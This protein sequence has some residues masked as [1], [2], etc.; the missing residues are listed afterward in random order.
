M[1]SKL[2]LLIISIVVLTNVYGSESDTLEDRKSDKYVGKQLYQVYCVQC[3]GIT[4]D[5]YGINVEDMSVLP[6]DHTDTK[7]MITRSD[8]DL[9]KAIKYGGKAV[10]KSV[11]MPAC[12][13]NLNDKQIDA[14][15]VY[16]RDVCCA[17]V[18]EQ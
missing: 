1:I 4:G 16:L 7:E 6:K 17:D 15:V 10:S 3:H 5:G 14:I 11:L 2:K 18:G 13:A 8:E 9:F 12:E